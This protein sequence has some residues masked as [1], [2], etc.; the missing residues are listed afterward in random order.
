VEIEA[1][2]VKIPR[3]VILGEVVKKPAI[4]KTLPD[5][6]K[7]RAAHKDDLYLAC[8]EL[9]EMLPDDLRHFVEF[10]GSN[11]FDEGP[12]KVLAALFYKVESNVNK[13]FTKE[14]QAKQ[15]LVFRVLGQLAAKIEKEKE[16][17][18]TRALSRSVDLVSARDKKIAK[19][20]Q[21]IKEEYAR[22]IKTTEVDEKSEALIALETECQATKD[23]HE[24][25]VNTLQKRLAAYSSV[26][27]DLKNHYNITY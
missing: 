24:A 1:P 13:F 7:L 14:I 19:A 18:R 17:Q 3:P 5:P 27:E 26:I 16:S 2:L 15:K 10:P 23:S 8:T 21:A 22:K 9:I 4:K 12:E 25:E 6:E 20:I 11:A